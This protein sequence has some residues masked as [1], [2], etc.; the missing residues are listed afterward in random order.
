ML[1][2]CHPERGLFFA[3]SG[4]RTSAVEG[5]LHA[6]H[7]T[8]AIGPVSNLNREPEW[9]EHTRGYLVLTVSS[10]D[11]TGTSHIFVEPDDGGRWRVY[12]RQL[13]R[14]ELI[15]EPTVYWVLWVPNGDMP[16]TALDPGHS[17]DAFAHQLEFRDVCGVSIRQS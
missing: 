6:S 10:V 7:P 15:D 12:G 5:S 9:H 3:Q 11:H 14:D 13:D 16:A 17:P 8:D 2:F 1:E 4:Q